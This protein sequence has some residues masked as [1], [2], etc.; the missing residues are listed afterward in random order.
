MSY[1]VINDELN[2]QLTNVS[3]IPTFTTENISKRRTNA[4]EAF[5]TAKLVPVNNQPF[6]SGTVFVREVSGNY[7]IDLFYPA[8]TGT[9]D[10]NDDADNIVDFFRP[11]TI[12][13]ASNINIHIR[14][15]QRDEGFVE[16]GKWFRVPVFVDWFAYV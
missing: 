13:T 1:T 6:G 3:N 11:G 7:R 9:I 4:L 8:D 14:T 16:D 2:A 10:A 15:S 12:F 5:A